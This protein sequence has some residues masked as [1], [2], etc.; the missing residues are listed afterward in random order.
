MKHE[1]SSVVSYLSIYLSIYH[2]MA[3][4]NKALSGEQMRLRTSAILMITENTGT[5]L[6]MVMMPNSPALMRVK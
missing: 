1:F 3:H 4:T 6:P 5:P 2:C